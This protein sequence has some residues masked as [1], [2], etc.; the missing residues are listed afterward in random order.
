M[1]RLLSTLV[2]CFAAGAVAPAAADDII[3]PDWRG[4]F[5][6]LTAAWDF[7]GLEGLGPRSLLLTE[8][9]LL[10][11]NPG[12]FSDPFPG[13]GYIDSGV[14]VHDTLLGRTS[15]L[16]I[17][18]DGQVGFRLANY[19]LPGTKL[20]SVQITFYPGVG[21]PMDF[22]LAAFDAEPG[23]PPWQWTSLV[24]AIVDQSVAHVDGWQTNS[25]LLR[26]DPA[27]RWEGFG[28]VFTEYPAYVDQVVVDSR[29][30]ESAFGGA[31]LAFALTEI[32][33]RSKRR[34]AL[35]A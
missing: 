17:D 35:R 4:E 15:V 13:W 12:D 8:A 19:T 7:W 34:R 26:Y 11:A 24:S 3:P 16:E 22:Q 33:L 18:E 2:A 31:A 21:A 6:T 27:P 20:L 28:I 1:K 32:A 5:G 29:V 25:Y 23:D 14:Y 9:Q 30:P 10:Q